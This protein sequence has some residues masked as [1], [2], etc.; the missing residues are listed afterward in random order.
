MLLLNRYM[1]LLQLTH[2]KTTTPHLPLWF[3]PKLWHFLEVY[4]GISSMGLKSSPS[5][6]SWTSFH[7]I[8]GQHH[9]A[10]VPENS[11][12]TDIG[13]GDFLLDGFKR[14]LHDKLQTLD[15]ALSQHLELQFKFQLFCLLAAWT[16]MNVLALRCLV[17]SFKTWNCRLDQMYIQTTPAHSKG[18]RSEFPSSF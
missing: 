18:P 10:G 4:S 14:N 9:P 2:N 15:L 7:P 17:Y 5:L 1:P 6:T 3:S 8:C 13:P 11:Q 16:W 12:E